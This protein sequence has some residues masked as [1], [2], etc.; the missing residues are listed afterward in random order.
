MLGHSSNFGHFN[1]QEKLWLGWIAEPQNVLTVQT[2]GTFDLKPLE[3]ATTGLQAIRV[4]RGQQNDEWLWLEY[5]QPGSAYEELPDPS[6]FT[7]ALIHRETSSTRDGRFTDL[8]DFTP[9]QA[10]NDFR[11]AALLAGRMWA[12]PYSN[13]T[14]IVDGEEPS[15]LS[16]TVLYRNALFVSPDSQASP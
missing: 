16:V 11:D 4:R 1:A 12:D 14:L 8:L 3:F 13:L 7:G 15:G 5:R 6:V 9:V 10:P 2:N